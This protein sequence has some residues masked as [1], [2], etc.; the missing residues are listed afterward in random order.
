MPRRNPVPDRIRVN[1]PGTQPPQRRQRYTKTQIKQA[2][3]ASGGFLSYA[4]RRL[5]CHYATVYNYLKRYPELAEELNAIRESHI[6][7]A[8]SSLIAQVNEK[9]TQATI[10]FLECQGKKRGYVRNPALNLHAHVESGSGT[11]ADIMKRVAK[12]CGGEVNAERIIDVS[13]RKELAPK[14]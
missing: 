11:W 6:D 4:A 1:P 10:F 2:L 13:G 8:E 7:L 12:E 3:R 14:R 9:N 5:N